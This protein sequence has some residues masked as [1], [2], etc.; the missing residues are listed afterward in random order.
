MSNYK[1]AKKIGREK[2]Q[3]YFK[4]FLI[5]GIAIIPIGMGVCVGMAVAM[6]APITVV[7]IPGTIMSVGCGALMT[8]IGAVL[9]KEQEARYMERYI[10]KSEEKDIENTE[11]NEFLAEHMPSQHKEKTSTLP[12]E[13]KEP[14]DKMEEAYDQI[15]N[16]KAEE[17]DKYSMDPKENN[18]DPNFFENF[19]ENRKQI[20]KKEKTR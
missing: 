7:L 19:E 4:K 11:R 14:M 16:Y 8:T 10:E 5:G 15:K 13:M 18:S 20:D 12:K 6:S 9:G 2:F 3:E 1:E 17:S